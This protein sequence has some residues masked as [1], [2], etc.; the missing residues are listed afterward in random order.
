MSKKCQTTYNTVSVLTSLWYYPLK[1]EFKALRSE[2]LRKMS[3]TCWKL[4]RQ[5]VNKKVFKLRD[6][7]ID[8]AHA[9]MPRRAVSAANLK[10][11]FRI[12]INSNNIGKLVNYPGLSPV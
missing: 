5:H 9:R 8:E 6:K 3:L 12:S 4:Q 10:F 2:L 7:Q 11:S 1:V